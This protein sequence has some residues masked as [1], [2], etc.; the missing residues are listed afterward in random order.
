MLSDGHLPGD[1]QTSTR[2][3]HRYPL[4]RCFACRAALR[5][6]LLRRAIAWY[7]LIH[8]RPSDV[9]QTLTELVRVLGPGGHGLV[10]FQVGTGERMINGYG[11]DHHLTAFLFT[12]HDIGTALTAAGLYIAAVV[13][14]TANGERH[15]QGFV[16]AVKSAA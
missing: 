7:S 2:C 8:T 12:P 9:A 11:T 5:K 14:R 16:L 3:F 1:E 4:Q 10:G 15:D 6:R 13:T